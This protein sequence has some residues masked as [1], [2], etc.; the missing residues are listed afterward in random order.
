ML[1]SLVRR[2]YEVRLDD[3]VKGRPPQELLDNLLEV[4]RQL[5]EKG[6]LAAP[7]SAFTSSSSSASVEWCTRLMASDICRSRLTDWSTLIGRREAGN[8]CNV[9]RS[10]PG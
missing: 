7:V 3:I 6:L 4:L 5:L 8:P 9:S 10:S 2:M 1:D